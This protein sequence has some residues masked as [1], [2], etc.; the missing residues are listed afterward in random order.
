MN[1]LPKEIIKTINPKRKGFKRKQITFAVFFMISSAFWLLN[2]LN[3]IYVENIKYPVKYINLPKGKQQLL[4]LPSQVNVKLS[5]TGFRLLRYYLNPS[6]KPLVFDYKDS[7]DIRKSAIKDRYYI[8]LQNKKEQLSTM[9]YGATIL[10]I[11]PDSINLVFS[12]ITHKRV[13]IKPVVKFHIKDNL[14]QKG[15]VLLD[16]QYIEISGPKDTID[17][18]DTI[19]TNLVELGDIDKNVKR[20]VALK[21]NKKIRYEFARVNLLLSVEEATQA[22]IEVPINIQSASKKTLKLIPDKINVTYKVGLS[23]YHNINLSDFKLTV[24]YNDSLKNKS[25]L[26]VNLEEKPSSVFDIKFS[27]HFVEFIITDK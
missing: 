3:E 26:P 18:I 13:P 24:R 21:K 6:I 9:L 14:V 8:L 23:E 17:N 10:K 12:L 15:A 5:A 25:V 2:S 19:Y 7:K 20:N 1:T 22:E 4:P 27:P 16:P 11:N